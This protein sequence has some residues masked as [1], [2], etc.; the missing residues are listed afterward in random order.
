MSSLNLSY[1][2]TALQYSQLS[3]VLLGKNSVYTQSGS[4]ALTPTARDETTFIAPANGVLTPA[5]VDGAKIVYSLPKT[6]T[7]IGQVWHELTLST[8]QTN[9]NFTPAVPFNTSSN[10]AA[11]AAVGTPQAEYTENIGDLI[12]SQRILRYGST[13]LQVFDSEAILARRKICKNSVNIQYINA[14]VLGNLSPG[15]NSE[16]TL[17]DAFYNGVTLRTP[18]DELFFTQQLDRAWMPESLALEGTIELVLRNPAQC[19]I[20]LSGSNAEFTGGAPLAARLPT[21][22]DV[23]LRY[24]QIT[25]SAAEKMNRLTLYKSPEGAVNLFEDLEMQTQF[26]VTPTQAAVAGTSTVVLN[27]PLSN[28]RMDMKEL[29]FYVRVASDTRVPAAGIPGNAIAVPHYPSLADFR[30]SRMGSDRSTASILGG[31]GPLLGCLLPIISYK[32][33]AAGKDMQNEQPEFH[34]RGVD[35]KTYHPDAEIADFI[36]HHS[37]A[38]YPEDTRNATGHVSTSV[39]GNLTLQITMINPQSGASGVVL[40]VDAYSFAYNLMQSR[41]GAITKALQ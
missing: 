32:L 8:A 11:A 16:Q 36:Y 1:P 13:P 34:I 30:G 40:Q 18:L 5:W 19:I 15:G 23:R 4:Q 12:Y 20:T 26:Q 29:V 17:I 27:V 38:L 24:Q 6:A 35:R 37:F 25:L 21:I 28:F 3:N 7:L 10:V 33:V 31:A 39:L 14:E 22:T 2:T 41:S 9:P